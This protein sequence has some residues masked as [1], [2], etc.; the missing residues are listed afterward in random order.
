[1]STAS[2]YGLFVDRHGVQHALCIDYPQRENGAV[3]RFVSLG[4]PPVRL[5]YESEDLLSPIVEGRCR[6]SLYSEDD[7]QFVHLCRSREGEVRVS[8]FKLGIPREWTLDELQHLSGAAGVQLLW[9]GTL[10]PESYSEP[11]TS[12]GGYMVELEAC[13]LGV[14]KRKKF[15][16]PKESRLELRQLISK[17]SSPAGVDVA[18]SGSQWITERISRDGDVP[19]RIAPANLYVSAALFNQ[20][21]KEDAEEKTYYEL[22]EGVL[23][24]LSLRLE[25][26]MGRLLVYDLNSLSSTDESERQALFTSAPQRLRPMG[27]DAEVMGTR[28]YDQLLLTVEQSL[29]SVRASYRSALE[30]SLDSRTLMSVPRLDTLGGYDLVGYKYAREGNEAIS[31]KVTIGED[32]AMLVV[33]WIPEASH[34]VGLVY[35]GT[36]RQWVLA[37]M[38]YHSASS[39]PVFVDEGNIIQLPNGHVRTTRFLDRAMEEDKK[40]IVV[41][42]GTEER[43][44]AL[45]ALRPALTGTRFYNSRPNALE[46]YKSLK[47]QCR[48]LNPKEGDSL[49]RLTSVNLNIPHVTVDVQKSAC[50]RLSA[51]ML[52]SLSPSIFQP[53]DQSNIAILMGDKRS[54]SKDED[55]TYFGDLN[56][57]M[58]DYMNSLGKRYPQMRIP[59]D[60]IAYDEMGKSWRL[61]LGRDPKAKVGDYDRP[62]RAEWAY[63][64]GAFYGLWW[65]PATYDVE[66]KYRE[67][68]PFLQWGYNTKEW[69][70]SIQS[71]RSL[72]FSSWQKANER[73]LGRPFSI[74]HPDL[75]EGMVIPMPPVG[76]TR[77]SLTIFSNGSFHR[78]GRP[79]ELPIWDVPNYILLKDVSLSLS[80]TDAAEGVEAKERRLLYTYHEEGQERLEHKLLLS[81]G[82]GMHP[83]S[84]AILRTGT[85]RSL[86]DF[87]AESRPSFRSRYD[88]RHAYGSVGTLPDFLALLCGYNY[89]SQATRPMELRGTFS[90]SDDVGIKEYVG[91]QY[92]RISE[93]VDIQDGSS[94]MILH[95]LRPQ[96]GGAAFVP[97]VLERGNSNRPILPNVDWSRYGQLIDAEEAKRLA[98]EEAEAKAEEAK[99]H[100]EKEAKEAKEE[101]K[102]YAAEKAEEAKRWN[103]HTHTYD[104][105]QLDPSKYYAAVIHLTGSKGIPYKQP[106]YFEI[107]LYAGL[108]PSVPKPPYATHPHGFFLD[109]RWSVNASGYGGRKENRVITHYDKLSV[110]QGE[111]VVSAPKQLI[112]LSAEYVYLRGGGRYLVEVKSDVAPTFHLA[113]ERWTI[114]GYET[115]G[116]PSPVDSITPPKSDTDRLRDEMREGDRA[117]LEGA[118]N[119]AQRYFD[120]GKAE[121]LRGLDAT[122]RGLVERI[123]GA[124]NRL[125]DAERKLGET[126][127][128]LAQSKEQLAGQ[129]TA[130]IAQLEARNAELQRQ[131]DK[132]V[133]SFFGVN[134]PTGRIDWTSEDDAK[135]EGDTYTCVPPDGVTITSANAAQYPN[136]GKSWRFTRGGWVQIADTDTTRAL[137]LAGQAKAAA[138]GK[139]THYRGSAVPTGYKEGDLWTLTADWTSYK[140]GTILTATRDSVAGQYNPSHWREEVR[141][142]DDSAVRDLQLGGVQLLRAPWSTAE[143]EQDGALYEVKLGYELPAGTYTLSGDMEVTR[144]G[145]GLMLLPTPYEAVYKNRPNERARQTTPHT[146][147]RFALTFTVSSGFT[148]FY[149]YPNSGWAKP[150]EPST[151]AGIFR[152]LKLERGNKPSDWTLAPED[153]DA[154]IESKAKEAKDHADANLTKANTHTD[155]AVSALE[156]KQVTTAEELKR[157]SEAQ[158]ADRERLSATS[159]TAAKAKELA[160]A[161]KK[162]LGSLDYL[163]RAIK[164]G[165]STVS[166]GVVLANILAAKELGTGAVRSFIAGEIYN[167]RTKRLYPA[168]AAGVTGFGTASER[169]VVEINHDGTGHFGAMSVEQGGQ[170]IRFY[171]TLGTGGQV[172][173]IGGYQPSLDEIISSRP[174]SA[175]LS[176]SGGFARRDVL[177][178]NIDDLWRSQSF[179]APAGAVVSYRFSV[180]DLKCYFERRALAPELSGQEVWRIEPNWAGSLYLR[181][182][183]YKEDDASQVPVAREVQIVGAD[184]VILDRKQDASF[185]TISFLTPS[186][187]R[188]YAKLDIDRGDYG[189][190]GS[191]HYGEPPED[192]RWVCELSVNNATGSVAKTATSIQETVISDKGI[193]ILKSAKRFVVISPYEADDKPVLSVRGKIDI[194]GLLLSAQ[195]K[196]NGYRV[197]RVVSKWGTLAD[198]LRIERIGVG[199]WRI[200][201][202]LGHADYSVHASA[203]SNGY[204]GIYVQEQRTH[205][206]ELVTSDRSDPADGLSFSVLVFGDPK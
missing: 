132:Q 94:K 60:L 44:G 39:R 139:V 90:A 36:R 204:G 27:D 161:A 146:G 98:A 63:L 13:D 148:G 159:D 136:V 126:Q 34:G 10:D 79:V 128:Q 137:A 200:T 72:S 142:T 95:E 191:T 150:G 167:E 141:Y 170:I 196:V 160:E 135:H 21:G 97:Q 103:V 17:L 58:I 92:I 110:L 155:N 87:Y 157:V 197:E 91:R 33:S 38:L 57:K 173:R 203:H 114:K 43:D 183:I 165:E 4:V 169:R 45:L 99:R 47:E 86:Y 182:S 125:T 76:A 100:A 122:A 37:P 82:F 74:S 66:T 84:P 166:G 18:F 171:P 186:S 29:G 62:N 25:Q 32:A 194:P 175:T 154:N 133:Q 67:D 187:G 127:Q 185:S 164:D 206:F 193:T 129:L 121:I 198:A 28:V 5:S 52:L 130:S 180:R 96:L 115:H 54:T 152:R 55:D 15:V 105:T 179:E 106:A 22:L 153:V 144:Q 134:P 149:L 188:Y 1:M 140:K 19:F 85:G 190:V 163:A 7:Q 176:H 104:L 205:S 53:L 151:G 65:E 16:A 145:N 48:R 174:Y 102:D 46:V 112:A 118:K 78:G 31:R 68:L 51:M 156:R 107:S 35:S 143:R 131:V 120:S 20:S 6:F 42:F 50:L 64:D 71:E 26:R 23:R 40:G 201:H 11:Y 158:A 108:D 2:Y 56:A 199:R 3:R 69:D 81:D 202:N 124:D 178:D 9:Q 116:I 61:R 162:G 70:N 111:E 168:F 138:D 75:G 101:A 88:G 83:A 113:T 49:H 93:E 24:S 14:L 89:G 189:E 30:G 147:G 192:I 12:R 119:A 184:G 59:F 73:L 195:V 8:L 109:L 77:L 172:L 177:R 181:I 41:P 80:D 117:T 123:T